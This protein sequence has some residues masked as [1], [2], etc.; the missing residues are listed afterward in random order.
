[1]RAA[2]PTALVTVGNSGTIL[3]SNDGTRWTNRTSGTSAQLNDIAF[4]AGRFVAV[5]NTF[6]GVGTAL[7]SDHGATWTPTSVPANSLNGVRFAANLWIAVGASGRILTSPD[8]SNWTSRFLGGTSATLNK[9]TFGAGLHVVVGNAGTVVTSPDGLTWDATTAPTTANL[10]DVAFA[11][12][13]FV[14]VGAG[15]VILTSPNGVTWSDRSFGNEALTS[16]SFANGQFL[17]T[18]PGSNYFVSPD[19]ITWTAR[20]TGASDAA[21]DSAA[22]GDERFFVG[23]NAAILATGAPLISGP[24]PQVALV[25]A[26]LTLGA[27][28][29]ASAYPL[30]YQWTK[31]GVAIPGATAPT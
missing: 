16:V 8:G 14:A 5:G 25:G 13:T 3:Q 19:G 30:T 27:A 2:S 7:V 31:D 15:G 22:F 28:V 20:F 1:M 21:L 29:T 12:G 11:A 4:G 6:G 26:P 24:A 18:G 9:T 17:A 10:N 23:E